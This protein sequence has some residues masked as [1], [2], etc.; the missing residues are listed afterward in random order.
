MK[1]ANMFN[2]N[3]S[4]TFL[5]MSSVFFG[6]STYA[7]TLVDKYS[8]HFYAGIAGGYGQ[9][10]WGYL[11]PDELN[12]AMNLSTPV[13]VSEGGGI[14]GIYAGY[15]I[16][17]AFAIEA[18]YMRYP[19]ADLEF[20]PDSLFTFYHDER[21]EFSTQ[22]ESVSI[23]AK[24]MLPIPHTSFRAYSSVG[25]AGVPRFDEVANSWRASP[26]FAAGFNYII[27]PSLMFEVGTEYVAG[28]GQS[29]IEPAEHYIPFL[30]SGF[31]RIAYRFG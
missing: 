2:K 6:S 12:A 30:Y 21:T 16:I 28:Y 4:L 11:V 18:S 19:D 20:D 10:T 22:T 5:I 17:P 29:E 31:A 8:K 15:E 7:S 25:V 3:L 27:N 1:Q 9:T 13:H 26:T 14:W 24:L 23:V